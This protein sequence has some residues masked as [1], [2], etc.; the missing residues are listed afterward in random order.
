[1][2]RIDSLAEPSLGNSWLEVMVAMKGISWRREN[3]GSCI[4]S[5]GPSEGGGILESSVLSGVRKQK[6]K[7]ID[8]DTKQ[9]SNI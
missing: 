5:E 3:D 1:M 8:E 7:C 4:I 2:E 9:I 6:K